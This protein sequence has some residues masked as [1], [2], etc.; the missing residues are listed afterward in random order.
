M[1][2]ITDVLELLIG[3]KSRWNGKVNIEE[4][5]YFSDTK[6]YDCSITILDKVVKQQTLR[7]CTMIHEA[8]HALSPQYSR[9]EYDALIGWEEGVIEQLQRLLRA[10]I[11][12]NIGVIINQE[13]LLDQEKTHPYSRYIAV[14]E[15]LRTQLGLPLRDF[16]LHLLAIKLPERQTLLMTLGENLADAQARTS[17][18]TS[19]LLAHGKLIKKVS[20]ES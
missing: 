6:R 3:R 2:Q 17:F 1:R 13:E 9:A 10:E 18:R 19:L 8:L 20:Y 5:V 11:L 7:W 16:Y 15:D 12:Q 14:L 4:L